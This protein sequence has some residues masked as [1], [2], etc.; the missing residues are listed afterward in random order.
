MSNV[1]TDT[2]KP[3]E[4]KA[5]FDVYLQIFFYSEE[6]KLILNKI[7]KNVCFLWKS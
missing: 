2:L 5:N 4:L 3:G 1:N 7:K 6:I